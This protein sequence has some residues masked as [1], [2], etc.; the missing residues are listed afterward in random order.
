M[1]ER[2]KKTRL[3][4]WGGWRTGWRELLPIPQEHRRHEYGDVST[5]DESRAYFQEAKHQAEIAHDW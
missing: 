3:Q 5:S 4:A 1:V 2:I